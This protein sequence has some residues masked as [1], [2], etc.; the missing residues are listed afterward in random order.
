[1]L[2]DLAPSIGVRNAGFAGNNTYTAMN[3]R[4]YFPDFAAVDSVGNHW[5][6][7]TRV[8]ETIDVLRKDAAALRWGENATALMEKPWKYVKVQQKEYEALQPHRLADL[9]ALRAQSLW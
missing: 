6:L 4:S 3:L 9:A 2:L 1:M 5:L 8:Q 7:E